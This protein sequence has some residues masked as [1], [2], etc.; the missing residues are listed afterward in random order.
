[1]PNPY[2]PNPYNED[3]DRARQQP[4]Y[5]QPGGP[6]P[7]ASQEY[8]KGDGVFQI[9]WWVIVI[10]FCFAAWPIGVAMMIINHLL[11]MGKIS[12][13]QSWSQSNRQTGQPYTARPIYADPQKAEKMRRDA[14]RV[15]QRAEEAAYKAEKRVEIYQNADRAQAYD[16]EQTARQNERG[17][18]DKGEGW[19]IALTVLG[20]IFS[21]AMVANL[22]EAVYWL[23]EALTQGGSYWTWLFQD[24]AG[25]VTLL[26]AGAGFLF[27]GWKLRTGRRM[28]K[29][30]SNIVGNAP[31]MKMP[32]PAITPSAA[33][34]WKT[35]LTRAC[36]EKTPTWICAPVPWWYAAHRPLRSLPPRQ[37]PKPSRKKQRRRTIMPR[38]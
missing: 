24:L 33:S 5:D 27:A 3:Q 21:I 26:F 35:A 30:I 31:Y 17:R 12:A 38:F 34:T 7:D 2:N 23:P 6:W 29:K 11:R 13:P 37:P 9:P 25:S 16:P 4:L 19:S 32:S 18:K 20:V 1:M 14:Q 15:V 8:H 10:T 22:P 28:R 36:L